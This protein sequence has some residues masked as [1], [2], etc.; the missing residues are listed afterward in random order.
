MSSAATVPPF[1]FTARFER[2]LASRT[3]VKFAS[4]LPYRKPRPPQ[5]SYRPLF[6]RASIHPL[7]GR[8][9]T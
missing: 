6:L 4:M 3:C 5:R 1:A 8:S 9:A 7:R 2:A